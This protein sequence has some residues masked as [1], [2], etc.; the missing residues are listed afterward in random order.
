MIFCMSAVNVGEYLKAKRVEGD[1]ISE[2]ENWGHFHRGGQNM[3]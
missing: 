3:K 2:N 1:H